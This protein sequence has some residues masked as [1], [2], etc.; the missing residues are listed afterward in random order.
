[1]AKSSNYQDS[2]THRQRQQR[3]MDHQQQA[4]SWHLHFLAKLKLQCSRHPLPQSQD[5]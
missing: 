5:G 3:R 2:S 4:Y 1:M